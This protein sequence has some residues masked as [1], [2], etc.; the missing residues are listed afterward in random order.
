MKENIFVLFLVLSTSLSLTSAE[1]PNGTIPFDCPDM[2]DAKF[3]FHFTSEL[4]ALAVPVAPFN[5]VENIYIHIYDH[6]TDIYDRLVRYYRGE[7]EAENWRSLQEDSNMLLYILERSGSESP[8]TGNM[9]LGIFAVVKSDSGVYL[10]NIVGNILSQQTKELLTDLGKLGI[11]IP[12]MKSIPTLKFDGQASSSPTRFRTAEG[13]PIHEVRIQGNQKVETLEI[14]EVLEAGDENIEKAVESLRDTMRSDLESVQTSIQEENEKRT[15]V[16][17]VKERSASRSSGTLEANPIL[18]FNRVTG[19]KLGSHFKVGFPRTRFSE[20]MSSSDI[21]GQVSYGFGN[22]SMDYNVG[23][24]TRPFLTYT[25]LRTRGRTGQRFDR[26]YHELGIN[27]R[28]HQTTARITPDFITTDP[29]GGPFALFYSLFGGEDLYNYYLKRG[30][31]IHF[32]WHTLQRWGARVSPLSHNFTL[33]LLAETHESLQKSTDWHLFNWDSTVKARENPVIT[34]G[35]VRSV[36][37]RYGWHTLR[38]RLGWYN[39]FSVEHSRAAFGSDFDFTR[40]QFHIRYAHPFS[41]HRLRTRAVS[42][43]SDASLPIQRRFAIGGPGLLNGYPLYA[44]AG[45]N[46][47]LFNIEYLYHLSQ[48]PFW[49]NIQPD[50]WRDFFL[51]FFFDAGQVW[52]AT[53]D[54]FTFMPKSDAGIGVQFGE[55]DSI[56]RFNVAQAFESEQRVQFNLLWFYSF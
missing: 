8:Q 27:A 51:I 30:L 6:N 13:S 10:L 33:T 15:A 47:Y 5:T 26:W 21:F 39:T 46:G 48:L 35:R 36:M 3:K 18:R 55:N 40:Y 44:F 56:L 43:L 16:I 42:S 52:N 14:L 24:D 11:D 2:T 22:R 17:T 50:F 38:N 23:L 4:I 45:D 12:E 25:Q 7:L 19:W 34:S 31:E 54:T 29:I 1:T 20:R 53:D 28:I 32:R 49:R 37:F 9:V 41:R